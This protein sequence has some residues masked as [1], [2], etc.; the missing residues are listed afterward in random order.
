[1]KF[2]A[3]IIRD[4]IIDDCTDEK[5]EWIEESG[6]EDEGK[7]SYKDMIFKFEDKFYRVNISR[8]GSY[9]SDYYYSYEDWGKEIECNEVEKQS[10]TIEKWVK[11]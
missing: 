10:V 9:F 1:M 5:F 8:S 11:V 2:N 3:S 6:W 7:Y 4:L